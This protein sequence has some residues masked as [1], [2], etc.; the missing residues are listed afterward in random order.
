MPALLLRNPTPGVRTSRIAGKMTVGSWWPHGAGG[1]RRGPHRRQA[2]Q[3]RREPWRGGRRLLERRGSAGTAG[4]AAGR[5]S[6]LGRARQSNFSHPC[7]PRGRHDLRPCGPGAGAGLLGGCRLPGRKKRPRARGGLALA[8]PT[9]PAPPRPAA[10]AGRAPGSTS[11]SRVP[12]LRGRGVRR[13]GGAP[14]ALHQGRVVRIQHSVGE[15][16]QVGF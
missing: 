14:P 6:G 1:R 12:P 2:Q 11:G 10:L 16:G 3:W 4:S 9:V 8:M 5:R 13:V 15:K 7:R